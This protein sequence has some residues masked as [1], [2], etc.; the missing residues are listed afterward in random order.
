MSLATEGLGFVRDEPQED[1][2]VF[3]H[4]LFLVAESRETVRRH[5]PE[6]G[7]FAWNV[8][9][10]YAEDGHLR[11]RPVVAYRMA[12]DGRIHKFVHRFK[13]DEADT[14]I[15]ELTPALIHDH[16]LSSFHFYEAHADDDRSPFGAG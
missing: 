10:R 8:Q 3:V 16:I 11:A 4:G 14:R 5:P 1:P 12:F 2:S 6:H 9:Y 15:D 7:V 13:P